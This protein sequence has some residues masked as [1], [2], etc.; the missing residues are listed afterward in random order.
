MDLDG[1]KNEA[2]ALLKAGKSKEEIVVFLRQSGCTKGISVMLLPSILNCDLVEAK[3][4]VHFS[5]AWADQKETDEKLQRQF[6]ESLS[7]FKP[8]TPTNT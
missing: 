7:E 5:K 1:I 8:D 6:E 2:S 4:I 3:K